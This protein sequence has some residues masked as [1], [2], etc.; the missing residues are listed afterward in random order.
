MH[1]NRGR[2]E[3]N[4]SGSSLPWSPE[5]KISARR[6]LGRFHI[7]VGGK[8]RQPVNNRGKMKRSQ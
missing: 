1:D 7:D 5:G 8:S 4:S 2:E 6:L 3:G